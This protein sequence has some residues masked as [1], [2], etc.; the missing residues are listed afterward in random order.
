[1]WTRIGSADADVE[2]MIGRVDVLDQAGAA[3][4]VVN[5][6]FWDTTPDPTVIRYGWISPPFRARAD[7]PI[8]DPEVTAQGH[9]TA[10]APNAT[11]IARYGDYN[12]TPV[13]LAT[14]VDADA[15]CL[16]AYLSTFYSDFRMRC[17]SLT[18]NLLNAQLTPTDVQ[19]VLGIRVGDRIVIPDA[20][21]TWPAGTNSLIVEGIG[22][23]ILVGQCRV[24]TINTSP[25][26]GSAPGIPGPWFRWG[27]SVWAGSD[28]IP[29]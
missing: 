25:V 11:S 27:S 6:Y 10:R 13:T 15:D 7:Q 28:L 14:A 12:G 4:A 20:P 23:Q 24:V 26:I 22:R 9:G 3:A 2:A 1:M 16:A 21:A 19:T 5:D 17:P 8:N 29:F 18:I